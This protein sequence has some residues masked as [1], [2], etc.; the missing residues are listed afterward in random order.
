MRGRQKLAAMYA[1][2][3]GLAVSVVPAGCGA[4]VATDPE[5]L[6]AVVAEAAYARDQDTLYE[7]AV[8]ALRRDL[9]EAYN[10]GSEPEREAFRFMSGLSLGSHLPQGSP[11]VDREGVVRM[12]DFEWSFPGSHGMRSYRVPLTD[13]FGENRVLEVVLVPAGGDAEGRPWR[14]CTLEMTFH[15]PENVG[16]TRALGA[17]LLLAPEEMPDYAAGCLEGGVQDGE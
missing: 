4:D 16:D 14:Y 13:P 11:E 7:H 6:A 17:R 3:A 9:D 12:R 1:A 2:L 5:R 8:P 15:T 10:R